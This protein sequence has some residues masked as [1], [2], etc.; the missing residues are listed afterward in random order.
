[1][2]K[3]IIDSNIIFASLLRNGLVRKILLG[4]YFKLF[5]PEETFNE[6]N[7]YSSEIAKRGGFSEDEF[8]NIFLAILSKIK[9]ISK[10]FYFSKIDEAVD[11]MKDID[12]DDAPFIALALAI[13]N[14]GIWSED[15][16]FHEQKNIKAWKTKEI[17]ELIKNE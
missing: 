6:T 4:S 14:D 9:I 1:M 5:T 3:F 10:E 15:R 2:K 13:E 8:Q 12:K 11:I 16:H 17:I 7:K